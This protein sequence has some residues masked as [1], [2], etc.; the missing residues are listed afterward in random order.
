MAGVTGPG[1]LPGGREAF[2]FSPGFAVAGRLQIVAAVRGAVESGRV[3]IFTVRAVP[4]LRAA[5]LSPAG[6]GS[7]LG[8]LAGPVLRGWKP[9]MG[10]LSVWEE[11]R[12]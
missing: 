5:G 8:V 3:F 1:G 4:S 9:S 12:D 6:E 11:D 10:T 7:A 2:L